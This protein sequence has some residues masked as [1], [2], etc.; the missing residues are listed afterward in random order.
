MAIPLRASA[1][2]PPTAE[3]GLCASSIPVVDGR[4]VRESPQPP[5]LERRT[6]CE[7]H[8]HADEAPSSLETQVAEPTVLLDLCDDDD[9]LAAA[10]SNLVCGERV[11]PRMVVQRPRST[12]RCIRMFRERLSAQLHRSAT[13]RAD[14]ICAGRVIRR[15]REL[16][17]ALSQ[18][19]VVAF[20]GLVMPEAFGELVTTYDRLMVE[21]GRVQL[22][23]TF[24]DIQESGTA[25]H[26]L[27]AAD[28]Y[29]HPLLILL[30][31]Y[32]LGAP[33]RLVDARAKD[34]DPMCVAAKENLPH[35]DG[36]PFTPEI[37]ILL[38]WAKHDVCGP[39]GQPF[40]VVPLAGHVDRILHQSDGTPFST[41]NASLFASRAALDDLLARRAGD[42]LSAPRV[43]EFSSTRAPLTTVFAAST[44]P[45]HRRRTEAGGPRSSIALAFHATENKE[46]LVRGT[47]L[48]EAD[49]E[50]AVDLLL[51]NPPVVSNNLFRLTPLEASAWRRQVTTAPD[52]EALKD[53]AAAIPLGAVFPVSQLLEWLGQ[54]AMTFDLAGT[55]DLRL[56]PDRREELRK[57]ARKRL[58]ES[59]P[60]DRVHRLDK[61]RDALRQ[62]KLG[63]ILSPARLSASARRIAREVKLSAPLVPLG[64]SLAQLAEDCGEALGR[65]FSLPNSLATALLTFWVCDAAM[66]DAV[67]SNERLRR[68]GDRLLRHYFAL[69]LAAE[70]LRRAQSASGLIR[71]AS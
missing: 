19:G 10:T 71:V 70:R 14:S 22:L 51:K 39:T 1:S 54:T 33:A 38:T 41:E 12:P 67:A 35:V 7:S 69:T 37:K 66:E 68:A 53:Q 15:F 5:P 64:A 40:V 42:S 55:F 2:A 24:L 23:H 50:R 34:T 63:H 57:S 27:P 25:L 16:C 59:N 44:V 4:E 43:L 11:E 60:V 13:R 21:A 48:Q 56:Y 61:W 47:S 20:E 58:R 31:E 46:A 36:S 65:A 6:M 30:V 9:A 17:R 32:A 28:A 3:V 29:Q 26:E 52:V 62:P 18:D 8:R 49:V 45:H